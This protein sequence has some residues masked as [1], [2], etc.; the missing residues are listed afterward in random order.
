MK[1]KF[2]YP[3]VDAFGRTWDCRPDERA[4]L[5]DDPRHS[6]LSP[7]RRVGAMAAAK[8]AIE[9][10]ARQKVGEAPMRLGDAIDK[11][12]PND[13]Y[14]H[15][16]NGLADECQRLADEN[17]RLLSEIGALTLRLNR[18]EKPNAPRR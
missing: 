16:R 8:E 9:A 1:A 10:Y 17:R 5:V 6:V 14:N 4:V 2:T 7:E 12:R 18:L 11:V 13:P 15:A 3:Y